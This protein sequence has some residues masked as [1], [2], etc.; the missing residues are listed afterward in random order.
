MDALTLK[1]HLN[2]GASILLLDVRE[3]AE[4]EQSDKIEG[5]IN[6]PMTR[7]LAEVNMGTIPKNMPI[8]TICRSGAR[9]EMV[10]QVLKQ[11]GYNIESLEGGMDAWSEV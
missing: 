5:S 6:I 11:K 7:V 4:Y 9:A 3:A 8:V 1:K 2:E 10:A